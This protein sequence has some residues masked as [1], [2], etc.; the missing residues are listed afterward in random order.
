[1]WVLSFSRGGDA[2]VELSK[3]IDGETTAKCTWKSS[4]ENVFSQPRA[5]ENDSWNEFQNNMVFQ[6]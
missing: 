3:S 1:M 5:A 2:E 6:N 4:F